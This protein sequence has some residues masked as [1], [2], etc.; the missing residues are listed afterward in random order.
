MHEPHV[1]GHRFDKVER[2]R[3]TERLERLEVARV[4]DLVLDGI[5]AQT[6]IDVGTGSG[7]FAE[8]F[9]RHGLTVTGIDANAA[10]LHSARQYV[11]EGNFLQAI[12]ED[13]PLADNA[14]DVVFLGLVLHETDD[15]LKTLKEAHRVAQ[16]CVA[17][18]EWPYQ[19]EAFGPGLE[20]R[21]RR[22]DM[23]L[24]GRQAG[25]GPIEVLPLKKLMMYRWKVRER[26]WN[27]IEFFPYRW[28][29]Q[30]RSGPEVYLAVSADG[31][32]TPSSVTALFL[33][34]GSVLLT[35]AGIMFRFSA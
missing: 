28:H 24:L 17:V 29:F 16:S 30:A 19:A 6:G 15:L 23:E 8:E 4:V 10:M 33:D 5:P 35:M 31:A 3:A 14:C 27:D 22:E 9:A 12:A 32:M 2:L 21:L 25:M 7:I 20:E 13:L 18:L 11:P 26:P 34:I 1:H